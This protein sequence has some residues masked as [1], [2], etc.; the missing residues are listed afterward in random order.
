MINM[1]TITEALRDQL[2]NDPEASQI[3]N[4]EILVD[5]YVNVNPSNAPWMCVYKG[6][7]NLEPRTLGMGA[8]RYTASPE[9]RVLVQAVS[10]QSGEDCSSL[11]DYYVN[12]VLNAVVSDPTLG[13]TV[14]MVVGFNIEYGY[15]EADRPS[16]HF[17]T[18]RITV[19]C[20]VRTS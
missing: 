7:M 11:L 18:A 4:R 8:G 19:N 20:E 13:G 2:K 16:I 1:Y 6:S 9:P 15:V 5:E 12:T 17:Q 3:S 14:D 10:Y